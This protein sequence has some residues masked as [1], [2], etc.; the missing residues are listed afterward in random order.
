MGMTTRECARASGPL[1]VVGRAMRASRA[2]EKLAGII[3]SDYEYPLDSTSTSTLALALIQQT[4]MGD[5]ARWRAYVDALPRAVD[6]LLAWTDEELEVLQGSALRERAVSR[7]ALVRREYDALFPAMGRACPEM[8]G[9]VDEEFF[10][11]AYATVLARAYWLP[12]LSCMALLPGLDLYNSARDAE[13]CVVEALGREE[14]DDDDDG[15]ENETFDD[16]RETQIT[17]RAGVGGVVAGE[18]IFHDYADHASGGAL[19]EFRFVYHGERA[20]GIGSHALDVSL[21]SAYETA[22]EKARAFLDGVFERFGV[23]KSLTYEISNVSGVYKDALRGLECVS[24]ECWRAARAL[25]LDPDRPAPDTLDVA[26]N[27]A[28]AARARALLLDVCRTRRDRYRAT[29]IE[30]DEALLRDALDGGHERRREA[31]ALEVRVGEKLLLD[32]V[33]D[34]L[35]REDTESSFTRY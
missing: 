1:A 19:L 28:H 23:R 31:M 14:T 3:E 26:V 7:R 25:T 34:A 16:E 15:D 33:I 4:R 2:D 5:D 6:A 10:R 24:E 35:T 18:E 27:A 20:R 22:E 21:T 12:D 8:F 32:D 9:D 30:E 13:K 17:L 29:T 11:W